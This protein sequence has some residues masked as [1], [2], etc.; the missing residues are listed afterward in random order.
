LY[1]LR[2]R[3]EKLAIL[4]V[5][6]A[7]TNKFYIYRQCT[8][9]VYLY[10]KRRQKPQNYHILTAW[11]LSWCIMIKI[12]ITAVV[13]LETNYLQYHSES[14]RTICKSSDNICL[15]TQNWHHC[16]YRFGLGSWCLS[17]FQ[18]F[19]SYIIA[20]SFIGGG[21]QC[22]EKTTDLFVASHWQI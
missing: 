10:L 15:D 7:R 3:H 20:V 4:P 11:Y 14:E 2:N 19:F 16:F 1:S 22:P 8:Y 13:K 17:H 9:I 5:S 12:R 18:Q 6:K 21:K